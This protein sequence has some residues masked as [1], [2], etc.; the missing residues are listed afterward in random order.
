MQLKQANKIG[1]Q[2]IHTFKEKDGSSQEVIAPQSEY[3]DGMSPVKDGCIWMSSIGGATIYDTD[4][5]LLEDGYFEKQD[6]EFLLVK[7]PGCPAWNVYS[8][9][10]DFSTGELDD[11]CIEEIVL[12]SARK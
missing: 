10:F 3:F 11:R 6:S 7:V 4:S 9:F 1:T 5:G 2:C 12:K 8:K